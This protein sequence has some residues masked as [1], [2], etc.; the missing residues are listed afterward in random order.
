MKIL[1]ALCQEPEQRPICTCSVIS[2]KFLH[3]VLS[4]LHTSVDPSQFIQLLP[5]VGSSVA[6]S[7]TKCYEVFAV[8]RYFTVCWKFPWHTV[9][10]VVLTG[11]IFRDVLY[12]LND[13][14][15]CTL[16]SPWRLL[17]IDN[18]TLIVVYW[19]SS[20]KTAPVFTS[21][22]AGDTTSFMLRCHF[23]YVLFWCPKVVP[24]Q[25]LLPLVYDTE[26]FYNCLT[27]CVI[28]HV[29]GLS[30]SKDRLHNGNHLACRASWLAHCRHS[31]DI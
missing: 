21:P 27:W 15:R 29:I 11:H 4:I 5:F 10:V 14:I 31:W 30:H 1:E 22:P 18:C 13:C 7:F 28:S 24:P 25:I 12:L 2:H 16:F 3:D 17:T 19:L 9:S 23:Y 6:C 8:L 20:E 26:D